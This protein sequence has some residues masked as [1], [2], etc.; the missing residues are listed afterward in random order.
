MTPLR[1]SLE[2]R[3][4]IVV[5]LVLAVSL[6]GFSFAV[7]SS[8]ER[9]MVRAF[10]ARLVGDAEAI[11]EA[12]EEHADGSF[13]VE[14]SAEELSRERALPY[15]EVWTGDGRP[16]VRSQGLGD[17]EFLRE[18]HAP[19]AHDLTLPGGQPGRRRQL[20]MRARW[21]EA[22]PDPGGRR[23][24]FVAVARERSD[25]DTATSAL[26]RLLVVS[27]LSA[28]VLSTVAAMLAVRRGLAPVTRLSTSI[29]RIDASRLGERLSIEG[30]PQ[31]FVGPVARVND[32]LARL[33]AAFE[34]ERRFA[35]DASHELRTPL[36]GMRSILE[37]ALLRERTPSGYRQSITEALAVVNQTTGL[38]ESL[39]A[40]VRADS[41][42]FAPSENPTQLRQLVEDCFLP[43]NR[44]AS[45]RGLSFQNAVPA[46][47]VVVTDGAKLQVV[48]SNLLG[49]AVQYTEPGGA[50]R[51]SSDP[52]AGLIVEV[53]DSG[54]SL[55][56]G[57]LE[58]IFERFVRLDASRS[59]VAKH[60][61]IG[62]AL[63][64]S[65][66][67]SLG[68]EVSAHNRS[69]GGV[70]FRVARATDRSAVPAN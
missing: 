21:A 15:F 12:I 34:R 27:G 43:L 40:L 66:S 29:E 22:S 48:L 23:A 61:G 60:A 32:V 18:I 65:L 31:E 13:E 9:E 64:R 14:G 67:R 63:V 16:I 51:V 44:D 35:G 17:T 11:G 47:S 62:L 39:L 37:V 70:A 25:L 33:Q 69:E 30:L 1:F 41:D 8:F 49:N 56:E 50:I 68:F 28:L 20:E 2:R 6:S 38:V 54:P 52:A 5:V 55:P 45:E 58:R 4:A 10:D 53:A 26:R 36:A 19:A 59:L 46:E 42:R 7:Y 3:L 24:V 57:D